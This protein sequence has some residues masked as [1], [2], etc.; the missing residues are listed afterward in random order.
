METYYSAIYLVISLAIAAVSISIAVRLTARHSNREALLTGIWVNESQTVR[1]LLHHIDSVFQGKVVW[2]SSVQ[3]NP[4]LLGSNL[5]KDLSLK[6]IFQG[7][8]GIY[9]D[10]STGGEFPFQLWFR[11]DGELKLS[12]INKVNGKDSVVKEERWYQLKA[13]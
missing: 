3:T 1:I 5:I 7:S 8:S 13:M 4:V 6:P 11:G 9:I 2:V 10:P 12:V